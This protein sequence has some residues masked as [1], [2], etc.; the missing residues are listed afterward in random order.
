LQRSTGRGI[1]PVELAHS[2][3]GYPTLA[4][5]RADEAGVLIL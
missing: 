4:S 5:S 3:E 1:I 2:S